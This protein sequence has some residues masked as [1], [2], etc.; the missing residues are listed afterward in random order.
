MNVLRDGLNDA[1]ED[2]FGEGK[3]FRVLVRIKKEISLKT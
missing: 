3:A 1:G 2:N